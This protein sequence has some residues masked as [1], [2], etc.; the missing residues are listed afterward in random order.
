[1]KLWLVGACVLFLSLPAALGLKCYYCTSTTSWDDCE[2]RSVDCLAGQDRCAKVYL[3][4]G[5]AEVFAKYC[6]AS[7]GCSQDG[8][9]TCKGQIGSFKCDINC[10][11]GNNCNAGSTSGI[12]GI[13]LMTCALASLM[14]LVKA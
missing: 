8:N 6:T 4:Y 10:C 12:S 3:K 9:P 1:M 14:I 11:D 7:A 2:T 13:L 5:S